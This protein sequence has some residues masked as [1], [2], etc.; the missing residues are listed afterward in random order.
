MGIGPTSYLIPNQASISQ[1]TPS[2]Y[3]EIY[4]FLLAV[5]LPSELTL[6]IKQST[7]FEPMTHSLYYK[8][9]I[10]LLDFLLSRGGGD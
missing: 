7:R 10:L 1:R 9:F 6:R 8:N 2:L 4:L 5:A 3:A